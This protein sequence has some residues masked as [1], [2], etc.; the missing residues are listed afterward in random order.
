MCSYSDPISPPGCQA[1]VS[2]PLAENGVNSLTKSAYPALNQ[3]SPSGS[4]GP[5]NGNSKPPTCY[6][7]RRGE[8]DPPSEDG[9]I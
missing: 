9:A 8:E 2:M 3:F 1:T 6:N 5:E 7:L 4:I